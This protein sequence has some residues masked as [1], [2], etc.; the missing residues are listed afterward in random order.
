MI[1]YI[2]NAC[3]VYFYS[4]DNVHEEEIPCEEEEEMEENVVCSFLGKILL[5][6]FLAVALLMIFYHA[7]E[8]MHKNRKGGV[9]SSSCWI[10]HPKG[11][12]DASGKGPRT[13]DTGSGYPLCCRIGLCT[14][15]RKLFGESEEAPA[16]SPS[17]SVP[18]QRRPNRR[19]SRLSPQTVGDSGSSGLSSVGSQPTSWKISHSQSSLSIITVKKIETGPAT[20]PPGSHWTR[21]NRCRAKRTKEWLAQHFFKKDAPPPE[22]N[23]KRTP[24]PHMEAWSP[25]PAP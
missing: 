25:F 21:E 24:V 16:D 13:E 19:L 1:F 3:W 8:W 18:L 7:L 2:L 17:G 23:P 12:K 4:E 22:K 9:L 20:R 15:L 11:K 14:V 6:Y 10:K 5:F